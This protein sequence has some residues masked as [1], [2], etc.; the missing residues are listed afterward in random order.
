MNQTIRLLLAYDGRRFR[1]WAAQRDPA[2]PDR[3]RGARRRAVAD[4]IGERGAALPWPGGP[5]PA[6]TRGGRSVS[7]ATTSG[8][9]PGADPAMRST[10][11]GARGRGARRA[12]TPRRVPTHGSRRRAR[13]Y[14]Y[15]STRVRSPIRSTPGSCGT[16]PSELDLL[17]CG[18]R[19]D[20]WWGSTT[21]RRS[22]ATRAPGKSTVRDLQRVTVRREV[23]G[24]E[25]GFR[26]ERVPAPDGP[27]AR[28]DAGRRGGGQAR[29]GGDPRHPGR[30]GPVGGAAARRPPTGSPSSG[31]S[32][33]TLGAGRR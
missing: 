18:R 26:A 6:C 25:F 33:A 30:Q 22:A 24:V 5:T 19:R 10:A 11:A 28:R 4:V 21:S 31:W 27:V 14:R 2:H 7:F 9:R 20:S 16:A 23:T 15:G 29:A 1:G 13:E 32:T 3:R 17:R 12:S 8:R